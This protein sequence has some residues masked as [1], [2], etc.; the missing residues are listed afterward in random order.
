MK[1]GSFVGGD[2]ICAMVAIGVSLP[3]M[4]R[5]VVEGLV[6][7]HNYWLSTCVM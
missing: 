1:A 3:N 6:A 7:E 4:E 5:L 2:V